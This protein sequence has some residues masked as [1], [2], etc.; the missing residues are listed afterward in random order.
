MPQDLLKT[1]IIE[2]PDVILDTNPPWFFYAEEHRKTCL[3]KLSVETLRSC[4]FQLFPTHTSKSSSALVSSPPDTLRN[5]PRNKSSFITLIIDDLCAHIQ[6]LS[7][8]QVDDICSIFKEKEI[9]LHSSQ[10]KRDPIKIGISKNSKY[11]SYKPSQRQGLG[12]RRNISSKNIIDATK[13]P[14]VFYSI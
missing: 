4:V 7:P 11:G 10:P 9:I 2:V 14:I 3:A 13:I 6:F 8:L 1:H 5:F 12:T